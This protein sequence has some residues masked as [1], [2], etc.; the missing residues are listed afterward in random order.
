MPKRR[1]KDNEK[2]RIYRNNQRHI[3]YSSTAL[4]ER[5]RYTEEDDKLI[6][7]HEIPDRLLSEIIHHSV[8]SIQ[9]RRSRIKGGIVK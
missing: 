6:L 9:I 8:Q 2:E 7:A 1:Y 5:S 4:Y 3:N